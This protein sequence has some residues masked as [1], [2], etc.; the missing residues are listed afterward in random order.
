MLSFE[1]VV[2]DAT[3]IKKGHEMNKSFIHDNILSKLIKLS[4]RYVAL[5]L[6]CIIKISIFS[7]VSINNDLSQ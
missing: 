5:C 1:G 3:S 6:S 7:T 2:F 4:R